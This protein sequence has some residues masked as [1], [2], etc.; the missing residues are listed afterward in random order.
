MMGNG[1]GYGYGGW[2]VGGMLLTCIFWVVVIGLIIWGITRMGRHG[3]VTHSGQ[4]E[5][6]A[7]DVAKERYAKGEIDEKEFSQIKKNLS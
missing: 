2:G 4:S 6:N 1:F 3:Y 7:L 5:S